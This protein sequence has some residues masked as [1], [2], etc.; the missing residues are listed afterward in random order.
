MAAAAAAQQAPAAAPLPAAAGPVA[1]EGAG[2]AA[3]PPA[4]EAPIIVFD[5]LP[6]SSGG[7]PPSRDA[8]PAMQVEDRDLTFQEKRAIFSPEKA[9]EPASQK[10]RIVGRLAVCSLEVVE[11]TAVPC[12]YDATSEIGKKPVYDARSGKELDPEL[13]RAGR[14]KERHHMGDQGLSTKVA[15][16]EARGKRVR[17]MWLDEQRVDDKRGSLCMQPLRGHGVQP[18]RQARHLHGHTTAEGGEAQHIEGRDQSPER[19]KNWTRVLGLYDIVTAFWHAMM[20][21]DEPIA[22]ITPNG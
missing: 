3:P 2:P 12:C 10:Q 19:L 18:V 21:K 16:K 20:P 14:E 11:E 1:A 6:S 4:P 15:S 9:E 8:D 5:G 22:V 7:A 17:S 13:V